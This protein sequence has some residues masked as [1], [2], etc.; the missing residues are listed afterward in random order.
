M[1][2]KNEPSPRPKSAIDN[3]VPKPTGQPTLF[4]ERTATDWNGHATKFGL[5]TALVGAGFVFGGHVAE[6]KSREAMAVLQAN[7]VVTT[8]EL[9]RSK[10]ELSGLS[11]AFRELQKRLVQKDAQIGQ[12]TATVGNGRN[13]DYLRQQIESTKREIQSE[14][15]P[16]LVQMD[17]E[18]V[19]QRQKINIAR[20]DGH[21]SQL[22]D[23]FGE[24]IKSGG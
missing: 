6:S 8:A 5:I 18:K 14:Q 17:R 20:L 19:D 16:L 4:S 23:K 10:T 9:A 1:R 21:L 15:F 3:T 7:N 11:N 24:C 2:I 22:V 12:L 13:W